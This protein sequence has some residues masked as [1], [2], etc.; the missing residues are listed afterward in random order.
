MRGVGPTVNLK[1]E[2]MM[3]A[4]S[5]FPVDVI[6]MGPFDLGH[7]SRFL[8]REGYAERV[9]RWPVLKSLISANGVF[10][11]AAAPPA[12]FIIKEVRGPRIK[13]GKQ[14]LKVGFLGL[15]EPRHVVDGKDQSVKDMYEAARALVPALRKKCD[16]LVL[17]TQSDF[18]PAAKLAAEN[19]EVDVV[20]AGNT[21]MAYNPKLIGKTLVVS[22]AP[23]NAQQGDLRLYVDESGKFSFKFRSTDL[24]S[25]APVDAAADAFVQSAPEPKPDQR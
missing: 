13:G 8:A 15:V 14:S 7:A 2:R 12:A 11:P 16:V 5:L 25:T 17:L 24:D 18:E 20:I 1:N 22:T 3:H 10:A 19:P 21:G 23:L 6:N 4:L 9:A